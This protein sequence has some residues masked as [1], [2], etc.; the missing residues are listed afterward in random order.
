MNWRDLSVAVCEDVCV[1]WR[2]SA[3]FFVEFIVVCDGELHC[4]ILF[5][6]YGAMPVA[7]YE[8]YTFEI[9]QT[10]DAP[11]LGCRCRCLFEW[12]CRVYYIQ[13]GLC[14]WYLDRTLCRCTQQS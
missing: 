2:G 9:T 4:H 10:E 14:D 12:G 7:M 1:R 13:R 8:I 3:G 6:I 5:G 11:A